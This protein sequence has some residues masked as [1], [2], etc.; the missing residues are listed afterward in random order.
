MKTKTK[1]IDSV[2][3]GLRLS[4]DAEKVAIAN[5]MLAFKIIETTRIPT[6]ATDGIVMLFNPRYVASLSTSQV[7]GLITHELMHVRLNH[8]QRFLDSVYDNH[9]AAN[10]AMDDEI[11]PLVENA[12]YDLPDGGCYPE[13]HGMKRGLS[14]ESYYASRLK[15]T[16]ADDE[17]EAAP[18]TQ[19][20]DSSDSDGSSD[21]SQTGSDTASQESQETEESAGDS[22]GVGVG[23]GKGDASDESG[24]TGSD[25]AS[26][27]SQ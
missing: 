2:L 24:E 12:G 4:G 21:R 20:S 11:N 7:I 25:T 8:S 14:W 27:E 18:Q 6:A 16:V 22:E 5:A 9:T 13:D 15:G 26:Q 3:I 17:Q 1:T 10:K 23:S 19:A